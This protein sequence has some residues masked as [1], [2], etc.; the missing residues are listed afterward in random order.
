[1]GLTVVIV[2]SV[3]VSSSCFTSF[4]DCAFA[5]AGACSLIILLYQLCEKY[6]WK[7]KKASTIVFNGT[8]IHCFLKDK[9]AEA[10]HL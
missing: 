9:F 5:K 4:L 2:I 8:Y 6:Q 3:R 1:M 7:P 10:L